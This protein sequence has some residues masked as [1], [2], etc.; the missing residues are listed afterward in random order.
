MEKM[1]KLKDP[2]IINAFKDIMNENRSL[3]EENALL[4]GGYS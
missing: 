1:I 4:K 2:T 3:K